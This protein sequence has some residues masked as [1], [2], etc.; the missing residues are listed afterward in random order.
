MPRAT[1]PCAR[2]ALARSP[3]AASRAPYRSPSESG[4]VPF[5]FERRAALP[6]AV[7]ARAA[8]EIAGAVERQHGG[9]V[10]GRSENRPRRRAPCDAPPPAS[11]RLRETASRKLH[12]QR[13]LAAARERPRHRDA[14]TSAAAT[15]PP[16][17]RQA[18]MALLAEVRPA[19]HRAA[20]ACFSSI[21]A[22]SSPSL[23]TAHAGVA[24]ETR[25]ARE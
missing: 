8:A 19:L 12:V 6:C 7:P 13:G 21:A 9:L 4:I 16:A 25:R 23:S 14:V 22:T 17:C 5:A 1:A 20:R 18:A 3:A 2:P 24:R 11:S 10:E 15:L